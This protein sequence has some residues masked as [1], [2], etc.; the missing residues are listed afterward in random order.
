VTGHDF[1]D[2]LF[3]WIHVIAGI[4]WIGNSMLFNWLDRNLIPK[5]G[6]DGEIWMVHSGGF[7][8]IEKKMLAP[9]QLPPTLHWF[10]WQNGFTWMSGICLLVVVYYMGNEGYLL[11]ANVAQLSKTAAV[12]LGVG[13]IAGAWIAYDVL[14]RTV[15][16]HAPKVAS[17]ISLGGLVGVAWLLTHQ[18][19]G[20]AAFIHVGVV[21]GTIM[22]GNVWMVILP[23]QRSLIAATRSGH[24]QDKALA[25]R[26]KQ[27][28]IH[29]NYMT[30]PLLFIMISNHFSSI[31]LDGRNWILLLIL[32][33]TGAVVRHCM[34][35][36]FTYGG[37]LPPA[38]GTVT[39]A[40]FALFMLMDHSD[41]APEKAAGPPVAFAQAYEIVQRRCQPCHSVHP[42][43]PQFP[44]APNGVRLDTPDEIHNMAPRI[45]ERAVVF[46]N[47]PFTNRTGMTDDERAQ[48]GR[49][50]DQ[51]AVTP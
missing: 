16:K 19:A 6:I 26:A 11:D 22:T 48:L 47:M 9:H 36:R 14:W 46:K 17:A 25:M 23:S 12:G 39:A 49:W 37:W 34:N 30:F 8:Q 18:L 2:L 45:R 20:R 43:E 27:R 3:R 50:I 28:S 5:P 51:G 38:L 15:G 40:V 32:M 13:V 1:A 33:F 24:E 10:K 31:Y 42:S 21:L 41:A 29:N 7:Y 44:V 35:I 4:M